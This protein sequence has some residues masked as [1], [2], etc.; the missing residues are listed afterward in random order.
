MRRDEPQLPTNKNVSHI[1]KKKEERQKD[2]AILKLQEVLDWM[3][4]V[5][6]LDGHT[7]H[8]ILN[9]AQLIVKKILE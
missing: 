9:R 6:D 1:I 5:E 2:E 4:T 7:K 8:N 3:E